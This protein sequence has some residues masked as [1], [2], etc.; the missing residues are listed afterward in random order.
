MDHV[1]YYPY[2]IIYGRF[3]PYIPK[4]LSVPKKIGALYVKPKTFK[5]NNIIY[6][7]FDEAYLILDGEWYIFKDVLSFWIFLS[8]HTDIDIYTYDSDMIISLIKIKKEDLKKAGD[9]KEKVMDLLDS[10]GSMRIFKSGRFTYLSFKEKNINIKEIRAIWD[11]PRKDLLE[12]VTENKVKHPFYIE[13]NE[14]TKMV[15]AIYNVILDIWDLFKDLN[16]P[17]FYSFTS[18]NAFHILYQHGV[19]YFGHRSDNTAYEFVGHRGGLLGMKDVGYFEG[20]YYKLDINSAYPYAMLLELPYSLLNIIEDPS[21]KD[22]ENQ[23]GIFDVEYV[24]NRPVISVKFANEALLGTGK[25]RSIVTSPE[26]EIIKKHGYIKKIHKAFIYEKK[27]FLKDVVIKLYNLRQKHKGVKRK[28]LK[29]LMNAIYGK[30]SQTRRSNGR[31]Y[32]SS[33]AFPAISTYI[34]SIIR[35]RLLNLIE[36]AGWDNVFYFDTDGLIVNENGFEKLKDLIGED[37]GELKIEEKG[38]NIEIIAPKFYSIEGKT[39]FAG[40]PKD[41]FIDGDYIF[42]MKR[43]DSN[44]NIRYKEYI[45]KKIYKKDSMYLYKNFPYFDRYQLHFNYIQKDA[46]LLYGNI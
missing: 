28:I 41:A 27:A 30:F 3:K 31:M 7:S 24:I 6:H 44:K 2:L 1:E 26:L 18:T 33:F 17:Y 25:I 42:Y 46:F 14:Y 8:Q 35:T 19:N 20:E 4:D 34:T 36:I 45:S 15:E 43:D 9:L 39:K 29:V 13:D 38:S 22:I 10:L 37:I 5:R 16:M 21:L 23:M 32:L 40:I 11:V 12:A